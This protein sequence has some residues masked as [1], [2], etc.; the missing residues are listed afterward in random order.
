[1]STMIAIPMHPHLF[2]LIRAMPWAFRGCTFVDETAS[3]GGG[4]FIQTKTALEIRVSPIPKDETYYRVE[5][6]Y[7]GHRSLSDVQVFPW[8]DKQE[9]S[10]EY[11]IGDAV[12]HICLPTDHQLFAHVWSEYGKH[13]NILGD[14]SPTLITVNTDHLH[15]L[16]TKLPHR[17]EGRWAHVR[18]WH[19]VESDQGDNIAVILTRFEPLLGCYQAIEYQSRKDGTPKLLPRPHFVLIPGCKKPATKCAELLR[20]QRLNGEDPKTLDL[21]EELLS[22]R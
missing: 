16:M 4:R 7:Q 12:T 10:E 5:M 15:T 6:I 19:D 18:T 14:P 21:P 11:L 9:T 2:D 17:V 3:G 13:L 8:A 22:H 1:M 20:L